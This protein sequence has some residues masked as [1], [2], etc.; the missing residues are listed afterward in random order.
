MIVKSL[1]D[2]NISKT[3][4]TLVFIISNFNNKYNKKVNGNTTKQII[5]NKNNIVKT[6]IDYI[7]KNF[8]DKIDIYTIEY[9]NIN[10]HMNENL[11]IFPIIKY[12]NNGK[13]I[14]QWITFI[15]A[16]ITKIINKTQNLKL[17]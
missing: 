16:Y 3:K 15:R 10:P 2:I 12:Y 11:P 7:K 5:E 17:S 8:N 14:C 13:F 4:G 9:Q 1:S 6:F